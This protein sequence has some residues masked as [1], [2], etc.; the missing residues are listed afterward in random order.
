MNNADFW[1]SV[2]S[3][4]AEG[5][6]P[7]GLL[8]LDSYAEQFISG[9]L[10]YQRFSPREQ[11]GCAAGGTTNVIAS[12]LAGAEDCADT[13]VAEAL[14]EFERERQRTEQREPSSLLEWP[15]RDGRR[16]SQCGAKQEAAIEKWA[17]AV[18]CWTECVDDSL[19]SSFG[20]EIAE[21]G[22]AKVYDHGSTLVKSIGLDYFILPILAL[23]RIALHNAYF[24]ET[25]LTVLGFGRN[26][27]GEFKI[28]CEQPFIGGS[29]V[30]DEEI[31]EYM[32]RMGFELKNPHNWTYATPSIYLSDMHDEN[33][34]LS[35]T[36]AFCVVD[37]DI[38]INTPELRLGGTRK[39]TNA[40]EFV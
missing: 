40:V 19:H 32:R 21:G 29:H 14:S 39:F 24:P 16:Q 2:R 5:F 10:V 22:E 27:K 6:T 1:A 30:S 35:E 9:R 7:E 36:G 33:V 4:I 17:K 12:L 11:H 13:N 15:S 28:I 37:C 25:Q 20:E 18:G 26:Q 34:I 3:I 23:D 38:R 8:K 31:A